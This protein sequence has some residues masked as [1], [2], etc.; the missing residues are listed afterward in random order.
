M[1]SVYVQ[2]YIVAISRRT[3]VPAWIGQT[4]NW[5][6]IK[7][8]ETLSSFL[9]SAQKRVPFYLNLLNL[10]FVKTSS[11][12][13]TCKEIKLSNQFFLSSL[14]IVKLF[15]FNIKFQTNSM[16]INIFF[17]WNFRFGLW[18]Q[19]RKE[20]RTWKSNLSFIFYF[21]V[22]ASLPFSGNPRN[23]S[24]VWLLLW[25]YSFWCKFGC[26]SAQCHA[27]SRTIK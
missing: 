26:A 8:K 12:A 1:L 16:Q 24:Y 27:V 9:L 7:W 21:L 5:N 15:P 17:Y 20:E 4:E 18:W 23:I 13:R 6:K 3:I 11:Y 19:R 14:A 2:K 22:A 10:P 25:F